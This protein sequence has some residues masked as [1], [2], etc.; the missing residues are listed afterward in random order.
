MKDTIDQVMLEQ[1]KASEQPGRPL[2]Q[3]QQ[4]GYEGKQAESKDRSR[5]LEHGYAV[6]V[7]GCCLERRRTPWQG[8]GSQGLR[9]GG[10]ETSDDESDS[11]DGQVEVLQE[12][13]EE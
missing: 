1:G 8:R 5:R 4:G 3:V 12:A 7:D 10:K 9:A 6:D 13:P 2:G 11:N